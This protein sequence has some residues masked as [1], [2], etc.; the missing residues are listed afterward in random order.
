MNN[1][2]HYLL[3]QF[4]TTVGQV[5]GTEFVVYNVHAAQH[6]AQEC[7]HCQAP[8]DSFSAF[9]Y[10]NYMKTIKDTLKTPVKPLQQLARRDSE[11]QGR[12]LKPK[13]SLDARVVRLLDKHPPIPEAFQGDQNSKLTTHDFSLSTHRSNN[14]F[15]TRSGDIVLLSNVIKTADKGVL[16]AGRK[17]TQK[18]NFYDF[19]LE[20]SQ[21]GIFLVSNLE[22]RRRYWKL[23]SLKCKNVRIPYEDS[24][25]SIPLVHLN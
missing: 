23:G 5:I 15:T 22:R 12:L 19:P 21:L 13:P 4:V 7:L 10:E 6:L 17:Y 20:S 1:I 14:C 8:L 3:E 2:A 24:H 9:K 18:G 11:A 16:L 25:L